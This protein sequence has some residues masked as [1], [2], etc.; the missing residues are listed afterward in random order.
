MSTI[1]PKK[2]IFLAIH[3]YEHS[4]FSI[5]QIYNHLNPKTQ[6]TLSS[7]IRL[8]LP[9]ATDGNH[10]FDLVENIISG[11]LHRFTESEVKP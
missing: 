2:K 4:L 5:S 10:L 7:D 9:S 8:L 3:H 11:V 1:A 6:A